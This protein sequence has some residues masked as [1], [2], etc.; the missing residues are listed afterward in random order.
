M[1]R[2]NTFSVARRASAAPFET[3]VASA[4]FFIQSFMLVVVSTCT[5]A[6]KSRSP[7][8]SKNRVQPFGQTRLTGILHPPSSHP[9]R[10]RVLPLQTVLSHEPRTQGIWSNQRELAMKKSWQDLHTTTWT[11]T[12]SRQPLIGNRLHSFVSFLRQDR[13]ELLGF[14]T[15]DATLV[16][17]LN[18]GLGIAELLRGL[19]VA[20]AVAEVMRNCSVPH[21][22][23]GPD[24]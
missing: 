3:S 12:N 15:A 17:I 6:P 10:R 14:V 4:I 24:F 23:H 22:V 13:K 5:R 7:Q 19:S 21:H 20:A 9:V 18:D 2:I 8:K 1:V 16:M 11:V